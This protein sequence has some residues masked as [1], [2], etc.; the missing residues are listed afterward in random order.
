MRQSYAYIMVNHKNGTI[1]VGSTTDI[2]TRVWEHKTKAHPKSFT[3]RYDCDRLA[4]F[5]A[6]D[7]IADARKRENALKRYKRAWKIR[8]IET[9]NPNWD[10]LPLRWDD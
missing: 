8:L 7:H 6:F 4:Y 5:E 1:Y 3:A 10:D 9:D 2:Q